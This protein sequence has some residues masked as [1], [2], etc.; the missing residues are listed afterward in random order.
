MKPRDTS[1]TGSH[2]QRPKQVVI[3]LAVEE[4]EALR[5][6]AEREYLPVPAWVRMIALKRA[7][8]EQ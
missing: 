1:S 8:G 5:Q 3:H 4:L 7:K 2:R 6:A